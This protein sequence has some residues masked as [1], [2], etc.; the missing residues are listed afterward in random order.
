MYNVT[1]KQ[2][3]KVLQVGGFDITRPVQAD[4]RGLFLTEEWLGFL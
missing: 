3:D 1:L 2:N 4:V